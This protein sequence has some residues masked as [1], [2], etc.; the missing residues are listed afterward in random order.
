MTYRAIIAGV[1]G[2]LIGS[3]ALAPSAQA[4]NRQAL[5]VQRVLLISIDGMH[6]V[7]PELRAATV[8]VRRW[9]ELGEHGV[10]YTRTSTSRPSDSFPG[11][12]GDR[13]GRYAEDGRCV[14]RRRL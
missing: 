12:D 2:A 10:N 1:A 9:R 11:L 8:P 5:N 3:A 6:A 14:L 13:V 4:W 7:D